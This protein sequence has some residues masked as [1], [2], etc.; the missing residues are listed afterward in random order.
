VL[1]I[2]PYGDLDAVLDRITSAP[3]LHPL[4]L[5]VFGGMALADRVVQETTSRSV[6]INLTVMLFVHGNLPFGEVGTSGMGA[7]HRH[8][9]FAAFSH[10]RP[11]LRNRFL[12]MPLLFSPYTRRVQKL[13]KLV[14][15]LVQ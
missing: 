13:P 4:V 5:Y 10:M 1:P 7:A 8:T 3:H 15:R 12:P 6:G 9:G 11:V 14:Q 2:V